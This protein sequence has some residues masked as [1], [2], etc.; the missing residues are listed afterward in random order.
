MRTTCCWC[1]RRLNWRPP[2]GQLLVLQPLAPP[3]LCHHCHARLVPRPRAGGCP[4]CGRPGNGTCAECRQW[5]AE[6]GWVLASRACYAYNRGMKEFMH[7]YKF[8][9]DYH[10]RHAFRK[11]LTAR[12]LECQADLVVPIPVSARRGFN[13]VA[14][15]LDCP[16]AEVLGARPKQRPQS[17]KDRAERLAAPQP[18]TLR[19]PAQVRGRRIVLVDDVYTTGRTLYHAAAL[20]RAAGCQSV[21]GRVLAN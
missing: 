4:Q 15:L 5:R 12:V 14:G 18:F 19:E 21:C 17:A 7:E 20:L 9:G 1:G 8:S 10:L 6:L 16:L 11:E 3:P 13:Q 2:L